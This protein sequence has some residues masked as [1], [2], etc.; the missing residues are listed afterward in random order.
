LIGPAAGAMSDGIADGFAA[1]MRDGATWVI[2]TT[3]GWWIDVPAIDLSASPVDTIR[4]Y[5]LWI[6]VV[7]ATAGVIW[8]G[9][10]LTLSRR[11]EPVL[12]VLRGLWR[13]S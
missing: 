6:A 3:V 13:C 5:V 11:P 8:Q 9:I 2:K 1:S 4:G 7:L 12:T 10:V